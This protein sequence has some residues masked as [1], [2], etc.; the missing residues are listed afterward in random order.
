MEVLNDTIDQLA[1]TDIY[2]T[3]HPD[4]YSFQAHMKNSLGWTT[5]V[6]TKQASQI[7]EDRNYNKHVF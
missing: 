3:L 1:L 4:T 5:Y 7:Q 6:V 2:R